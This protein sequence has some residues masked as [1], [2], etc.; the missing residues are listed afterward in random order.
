M[1]SILT[2]DNVFEEFPD[3]RSLLS[4]IDSDGLAVEIF[5]QI[6]SSAKAAYP[7]N[8]LNMV[9][10]RLYF[11]MAK[12]LNTA[13]IAQFQDEYR[14]FLYS[15]AEKIFVSRYQ[16]FTDLDEYQ[17]ELLP[18]T[19]L[20][21]T[22]NAYYTLILNRFNLVLNYSK[23]F[24]TRNS[25]KIKTY[26]NKLEDAVSDEAFSLRKNDGVSK[27]TAQIISNIDE[28]IKIFIFEADTPIPNEFFFM[29][30]D[31]NSPFVIG[32]YNEV[33]LY[34]SDDFAK[35]IVKEV[36]DN[37]SLYNEFVNKLIEHIKKD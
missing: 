11:A 32:F 33:E 37:S 16:I 25:R 18:M 28:L 26:I 13:T 17:V 24:F 10:E 30:F 9:E 15:L 19:F 34:L 14:S 20:N 3:E 35:Q 12:E 6:S 27:T 22:K 2:T 21:L 36:L 31:D 7:E 23:D 5:E 4:I 8:I 1:P 29:D